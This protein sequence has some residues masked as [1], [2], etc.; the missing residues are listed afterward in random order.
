MQNAMQAL[1][2]NQLTA[3]MPTATDRIAIYR[4]RPEQLMVDTGLSQ[5]PWQVEL[6]RSKAR[7]ALLLCARQVG[8]STGT[9]VRQTAGKDTQGRTVPQYALVHLHRWS[10][11]TSCVQS[12]ADIKKLF[13]KNPM[14]GPK[15]PLDGATLIS[16]R[17]GCGGLFMIRF[18]RPKRPYSA[19]WPRD[20]RP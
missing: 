20:V 16:D 14:A 5:D 15:N 13:Q 7:R 10:L 11:K 4:E 3:N 18:S 8:K 9:A 1:R 2:L 19:E 6:L 12:V 17:S